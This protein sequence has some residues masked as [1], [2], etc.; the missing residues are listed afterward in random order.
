MLFVMWTFIIIVA[1]GMLFVGVSFGFDPIAVFVAVAALVVWSYFSHIVP[2][3]GK[4]QNAER[5]KTASISFNSTGFS[6][7]QKLVGCSGYSGIA[8]DETRKKICLLESS[9]G[10]YFQRTIIDYRD[11][12]ASEIEED[13]QTV[14]RTQRTSQIG[15][16]LIGGL[17]LGGVG[18]IIGGLSG[19]TVSSNVATNITLSVT[20]NITKTPVFDI[21]LFSDWVN[22]KFDY[23][24][25]SAEARHWH[26]LLT[27]VIKQ[28]DLEDSASEKAAVD[29]G[30]VADELAKLVALKEQGVLSDDEFS[31]QKQ[32]LLAG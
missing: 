1:V 15:G 8:I 2:E 4:K 13:G 17:A 22:D 18:A 7:T 5:A 27:A 6:A 14:T 20:V 26:G 12:L 30:S 28:A 19:K 23:D 31:N 16:A 9:A 10:S 3:R 25:A 29:S 21:V 32:K 24:D 11:V